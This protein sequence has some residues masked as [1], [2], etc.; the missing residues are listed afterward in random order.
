MS[1]PPQLSSQSLRRLWSLSLLAGALGFGGA[2]YWIASPGGPGLDWIWGIAAFGAAAIL[3][4][5]VFF[6][7]C[8]IFAPGLSNY[9][10]DDTEVQGDDVVH[11]VR[12]TTADDPGLDSYIKTYA[13]ARGVS[14]VAIISGIMI[15][16]AW[17][18]F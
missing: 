3:Y 8:S 9:V 14:A 15:A 1:A 7:L 13:T 12:Y 18:F 16:V 17:N 2:L 6:L 4:N 5:L 10:E 11:V